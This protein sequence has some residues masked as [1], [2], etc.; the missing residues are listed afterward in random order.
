MISISAVVITRNEA[1]NITDCLKSI[2]FVDELIVVDSESTDTTVSLARAL[3]P[4]V[5]IIPWQGF[6][7]SK[8]FG[9]DRARNNW[10]LS[11]D[12]DERVSDALRAA[13]IAATHQEPAVA[14][15]EISRRTWYLRRW[16]VGGGWY[17]DRGIRLF[18]RRQGRIANVPV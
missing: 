6:A 11:I 18:D 15:F 8:N 13:I 5:Y 16:I 14:G 12:A 10:I 3:T 4:H 9:I 2:D 1:I 7:A 17:P